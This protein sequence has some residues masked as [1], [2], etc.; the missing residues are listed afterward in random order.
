MLISNKI[1]L[2]EGLKWKS[3]PWIR[4]QNNYLF[5]INV[6]KKRTRNDFYENH[7]KIEGCFLAGGI[8]QNESRVQ[9]KIIQPFVVEHDYNYIWI[10]E[11]E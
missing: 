2:C 7:I 10:R 3:I 4:K 6:V 9:N 1:I 5:N 11:S 8:C